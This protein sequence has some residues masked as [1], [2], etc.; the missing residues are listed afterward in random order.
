MDNFKGTIKRIK[1]VYN[2]Y[3]TQ[4][5]IS[6]CNKPPDLTD[7]R[8]SSSSTSRKQ[9]SVDEDQVLLK[10]FSPQAAHIKSTQIP[11]VRAQSQGNGLTA[12]RVEV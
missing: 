9:V 7:L 8:V 11:P 3:I 2:F 12:R 1:T 5:S 4:E 6:C 10:S